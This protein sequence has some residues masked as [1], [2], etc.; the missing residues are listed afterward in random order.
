MWPATT[1]DFRVSTYVTLN[2]TLPPPPALLRTASI[3]CSRPDSPNVLITAL[4]LLL[5]FRFETQWQSVH[6][7]AGKIDYCRVSS[8]VAR[9]REFNQRNGEA[10]RERWSETWGWTGDARAHLPMAT[11][12]NPTI[13]RTTFSLEPGIRCEELQPNPTKSEWDYCATSPAWWTCAA[14]GAIQSCAWTVAGANERRGVL[15]AFAFAGNTWTVV[16]ESH[17][18]EFVGEDSSKCC[19]SA[20]WLAFIC[21]FAAIV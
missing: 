6:H 20:I 3:Y 11:A 7:D 2:P 1:R 10:R 15:I 18:A 14:R 16:A 9:R 8:K 21:T 19:A 4:P 12:T 17:R 5:Q 13:S